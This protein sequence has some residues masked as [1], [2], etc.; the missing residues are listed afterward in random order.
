MKVGELSRDEIGA[1]YWNY[2][3]LNDDSKSLDD[4]L[5]SNM[6]KVLNFFQQL[7]DE[8]WEYRYAKDKWTILEVLQHIIDTKRIFQYRALS[9]ARKDQNSLL[10]YDHNSYVDFSEANSRNPNNLMEEFAAVRNSGLYLFRNFKEDM[11]KNMGIMNGNN[12]T[13]RAIGFVI[14]GHALHHTNVLKE[15]YL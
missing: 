9:I 11:M 13:P 4:L 14:C 15:R 2:I 8:K 1:F 7:P 6:E 5:T 10:G 12:A 3:S